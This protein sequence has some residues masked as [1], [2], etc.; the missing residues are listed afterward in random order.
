M[1]PETLEGT[2]ERI[3]YTSEE[4]GY[5]VARI[6]PDKPLG[7]WSGMD[8]DGLVTVVGNLPDLVPGENVQLEG[9][10]QTHSQYG[11]QFRAENVQRIAPATIE[12]IRRYLGSGLIKGIG[13]KTAAR[14]VETFGLETLDV[15]DCA[16]ERLYE[17]DGIGP[18]R[19]RLICT[20]W[21]EQKEIK[22]VMLF[23]QSHGVSTSLGVKIFKEYG[24]NSIRQV[25]QDPY[26]LAQDIHG[27]GFKTADKIARALGLPIDHPRRL[28]AGVVYALNQALDDGHVYL[29]EAALA[30]IAAGLLEVPDKAVLPAIERAAKEE[31]V[32][33][34]TVQSDDDEPIQ[35]VY[36]PMYYHSEVG[37]ARCVRKM[38]ATPRS[39]LETIQR[40]EPSTLVAEAAAEANV[41]ISPQQQTAVLSALTNKISILTGGPGTGKTTTLR[42]LICALKA[43]QHSFM[44]AS[45]TGRAAKRLSEATDQ[46][47]CTI[48]RMLGF[49]PSKGFTH[50]ENNPLPVDMVIVDE[51]SMLDEMLAY[52]LLRAIDP[53]SHLLLVGD[54]DQLPSVGA[55]DVLRDLL[56]SGVVMS[57]RLDVIFR[58]SAHSTIIT[59]A[60]RINQGEMPFFPEEAEDFFLF[61]VSDD[62]ERVSDLVVD[63]VRERIPKRFGLNP[64]SDIQVIVPMYRGVA[65]VMRLNERLQQVLNPPGRPAERFIGG[66]LYRVG[67]KVMQTRNNY[68]KEVFNGDIGRVHTLDH[69]NQTLTVVFDDRFVSYDFVDVTDLTHAYA[70]SVHRSQ[71]SEYPAV[72]V[73]MVTQHFMMLQRNLLYTAITRARQL[74][75]LV[76]SRKAI[77]IA[78]RNNK[79]SQRYTAL[80]ERVTG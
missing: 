76:G 33:L 45:P 2:V 43:H 5:T 26:R 25:E 10:W 49:S 58:Q 79:V 47:A 60:H 42:A 64:M 27:I 62:V 44:L 4:N 1:L 15:L 28:E 18:H 40:H 14:I 67:D 69:I 8:N 3:T 73:P 46:P 57:T 72:V 70:I 52:S 19:V 36:L 80:C 37:V 56:A 23:L 68:D 9:A 61:S 77:S 41:E 51:A 74:V 6:A 34:D 54:V 22:Q 59:N 63:I 13:P 32:R 35:A 16:P 12:G 11:R 48:H 38:L 50:N 75:V 7:F 24:N 65:G 39:R 29:P 21:A 20:A 31:M 78:V 55:G 71:G 53:R 17:V 66:R 30:N